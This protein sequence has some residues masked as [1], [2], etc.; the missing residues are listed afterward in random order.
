MD[1]QPSPHIS[2]D[3][4]WR[5]DGNAW[6]PNVPPPAPVTVSAPIASGGVGLPQTDRGVSPVYLWL[7]VL[8][9]VLSL[10]A[11]MLAPAKIQLGGGTSVDR[12]G[13]VMLL[14]VLAN[15][16]LVALD[17]RLVKQ[18]ELDPPS[19]LWA[20]L[21]PVYIFCRLKCT[22]D[23]LVPF[24]AWIGAFLVVMCFVF[25]NAPTID[26]DDL[27]RRIEADLSERAEVQARVE[28]PSDSK[29]REGDMA[30]CTATSYSTGVEH[31]LQIEMR[32][33]GYYTWSLVE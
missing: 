3:G 9:P 4:H 18:A 28:C 26:V 23:N 15:V 33:D 10:L 13:A 11:E 16:A 6:V 22:G 21:V 20:F 24:F 7:L 31:T 1:T 8:V 27:E 12:V 14:T 29:Y 17:A 32:N 30:I 5:W 25:V 2:P 19:A